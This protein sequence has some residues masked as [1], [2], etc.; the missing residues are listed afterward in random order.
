ARQ[1]A[2]ALGLAAW[3]RGYC[4][5]C[6]AWPVRAEQP[7]NGAGLGLRCAR[8]ATGW[9][10]SRPACPFCGLV[11]T[12]AEPGATDDRQHGSTPL[13]CGGCACRLPIVGPPGRPPTVA[14]LLGKDDVL[15]ARDASGYAAGRARQPGAGF[16]LELADGEAAWEGFDDD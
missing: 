15:R 12:L 2:P 4:P 11:G 6:G 7:A 1:L 3:D 16:R 13:E 9:A 10:P 14:S 5:I 8:C